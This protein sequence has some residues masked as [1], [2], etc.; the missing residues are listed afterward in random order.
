M[1]LVETCK[2]VSIPSLGEYLNCN[3][4]FTLHRLSKII[5]KKHSKSVETNGEEQKKNHSEVVRDKVLAV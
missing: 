4:Y 3:I 2:L 5:Q 1:F